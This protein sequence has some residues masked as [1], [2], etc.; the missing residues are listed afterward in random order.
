MVLISG[1]GRLYQKRYAVP[2]SIAAAKI[3]SILIM[4]GWIF[5]EQCTRDSAEVM[6]VPTQDELFCEVDWGARF[7][8]LLKFLVWVS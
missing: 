4:H 7:Q 6:L 5:I 2:S 1:L 3:R 8:L